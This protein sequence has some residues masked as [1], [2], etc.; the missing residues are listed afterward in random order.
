MSQPPGAPSP[1]RKNP[2]PTEYVLAVTLMGAIGLAAVPG[3]QAP[4]VEVEVEGAAAAQRL[5]DT[6]IEFRDGLITYRRD[7]A[8]FPGYQAGI[9]MRRLRGNISEQALRDQL[10]GWSDSWGNSMRTFDWR[11]PLGPYLPY[12]IPENPMNGLASVQMLADGDEFPPE[13]DGL[14]GWIYRPRT[15]EL[16]ANSAGWVPLGGARY[17]DL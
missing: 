14:S 9:P 2:T 16:R 15:G 12:G 7:H 1:S 13:P 4:P 8:S 3:R 5:Q 10:E 11:Y 6:L 17:F